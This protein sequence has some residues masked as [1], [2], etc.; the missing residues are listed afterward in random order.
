MMRLFSDDLGGRTF[1]VTI[2][3]ESDGKIDVIAKEGNI[4][5]L[6]EKIYVAFCDYVLARNLSFFLSSSLSV[7]VVHERYVFFSYARTKR[8]AL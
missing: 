8:W 2:I 3:R 4:T 6:E 7:K 5:L 1:D